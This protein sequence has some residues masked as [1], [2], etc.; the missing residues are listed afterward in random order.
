MTRESTRVIAIRL[1]ELSATFAGMQV[2]RLLA[3]PR[4]FEHFVVYLTHQQTRATGCTDYYWPSKH[5]GERH[6]V[7]Q[8]RDVERRNMV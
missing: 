7:V 2:K 4:S 6:E 5:G 1:I 8:L 3:L